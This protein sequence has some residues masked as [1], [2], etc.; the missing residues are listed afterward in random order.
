MPLTLCDYLLD[1]LHDQAGHQCR[2]HTL[3]LVQDCFFWPGMWTD[4]ENKIKTCEGCI[5][6]RAS[7][8]NKAPLVSIQ[9]VQP[10]EL[11]CIDCL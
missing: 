11:V 5:K 4:I 7:T 3:S 1:S 8:D 9:S 6:R 2:D 10:L